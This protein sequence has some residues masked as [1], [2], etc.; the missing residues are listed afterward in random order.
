MK[1][2]T[3]KEIAL[4]EAKAQEKR[5][6]KEEK[7]AQRRERKRTIA[8]EKESARKARKK[9]REGQTI[10]RQIYDYDIYI[11]GRHIID[12]SPIDILTYI[13]DQIGKRPYTILS[14]EKKEKEIR[15]PESENFSEKAF[16]ILYHADQIRVISYQAV[17]QTENEKTCRCDMYLSS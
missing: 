15:T 3:I 6:K 7:L 13:E 17:I 2:K 5:R 14:E 10:Y 9:E 11:D 4:E 12:E 1:S 8:K 16:R